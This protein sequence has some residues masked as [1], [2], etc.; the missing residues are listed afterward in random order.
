[1]SAARSTQARASARETAVCWRPRLRRVPVSA[2]PGAT[3]SPPLRRARF[4]APPPARRPARR[5]GPP[6][7]ALRQ[8]AGEGGREGERGRPPWVGLL[9]WPSLSAPR[10][11]LP[12]PC[13][14]RK[15]ARPSQRLL[16][17][18][19][20]GTRG[21]DAMSPDGG[22]QERPEGEAG[23]TG[24][25][26]QVSCGVGGK[27]GAGLRRCPAL[28]ARVQDAGGRDGAP[29]G[30]AGSGKRGMAQSAGGPPGRS[31]EEQPLGPTETRQR[32]GWV[33]AARGPPWTTGPRRLPAP[34]RGRPPARILTRILVR[35]TE[36]LVRPLSSPGR[37][38]L[39]RRFPLLLQGGVGGDGRRG[40][41]PVLEPEEELR[42]ARRPR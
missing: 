11:P 26:P 17:P 32:L 12:V 34:G 5:R 39:E 6:E 19:A 20:P 18:Q 23:R 15:G 1:M 4:L 25:K 38:R 14:R 36:S 30:R 10:P 24:R 42:R 28:A 22:P 8:R 3:P 35:I 33:L 27:R 9:R 29:G 7:P 21:W 40:E 31:R 41:R 13:Q 37:R 16:L 2:E